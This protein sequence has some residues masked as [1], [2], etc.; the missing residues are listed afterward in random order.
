MADAISAP[1]VHG[2]SAKLPF[3]PLLRPLCQ[4]G[5]ARGALLYSIQVVIGAAQPCCSHC[6][7]VRN[8]GAQTCAEPPQRAAAVEHTLLASGGVGVALRWPV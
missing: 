4:G 3:A 8:E 7:L 5:V 6:L 1:K 2:R